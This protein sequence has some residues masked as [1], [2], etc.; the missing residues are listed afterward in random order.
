M[1]EKLHETEQIRD[2]HKERINRETAKIAWHDLQTFFAS[3]KVIHVDTS[4]DLV[5]AAL[6]I[7]L[8][9]AEQVKSLMESGKLGLVS[10][11]QA[12]QW[13]EDK[14]QVWAVVI[15]PWIVVQLVATDQD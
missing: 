7:S 2:F 6:D 12:H 3:G 8:D 15:K 13:Y 1:S 10:D 4:T 5:E 14:A 11:D 9:N